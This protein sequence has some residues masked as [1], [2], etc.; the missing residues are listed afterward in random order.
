MFFRAHCLSHVNFTS[1]VWDSA[2][3]DPLIKLSSIYRRA[4]KIIN[5]DREVSTQEKLTK[6]NILPLH[7]QLHY[8]KAVLVYKVHNNL[9]PKSQKR[10]LHRQQTVMAPINTICLPLTLTN[11]DQALHFQVPQFGMPFPPM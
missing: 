8:N 7:A 4:A 11:I 3:Q 9:T 1:I 5:P 10:Y 2:A 6:L